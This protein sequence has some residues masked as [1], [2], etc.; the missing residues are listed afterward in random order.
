MTSA[1][2]ATVLIGGDSGIGISCNAD[3][4][5]PL[6]SSSCNHAAGSVVRWCE[7]SANAKVKWGDGGLS[8]TK[9]ADQGKCNNSSE[10]RHVFDSVVHLQSRLSWVLLY[11][12]T[13]VGHFASNTQC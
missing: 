5:A 7:A 1:T 8:E 2:G 6:H 9:E 3:I 11:L 4:S 10:A 13:F 12:L